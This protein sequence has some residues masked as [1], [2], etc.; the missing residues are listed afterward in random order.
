MLAGGLLGALGAAGLAR[1]LNVVRGTDRSLAAW[2]DE[3]L[4]PRVD[5]ALLRYLAVAH[6]GRGRGHW[7]QGEAP[8]HWREVVAAALERLYPG[9]L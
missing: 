9:A 5:A 7:A 8:P 2:N 4:A 1:G 6:C 3:A